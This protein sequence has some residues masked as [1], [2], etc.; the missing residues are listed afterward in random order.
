MGV[1][2]VFEWG[3]DAHTTGKVTREIHTEGDR[4]RRSE[5]ERERE[6]QR[7]RIVTVV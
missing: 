5:A 3:V 2:E 6:G 1:A 4:E 7:K